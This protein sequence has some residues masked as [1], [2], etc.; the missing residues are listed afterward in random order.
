MVELADTQ[1][2]GDVTSVDLYEKILAKDF[3]DNHHLLFFILMN[4][5]NY[6]L[7]LLAFCFVSAW[8]RCVLVF[9]IDSACACIC[10]LF[11]F[12]KNLAAIYIICEPA[13][14]YHH[15][16][17]VGYATLLSLCQ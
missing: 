7:V 2:L 15:S 6:V 1:D 14:I 5:I 12:A 3:I 4:I 13:S 10:K 11:L 17:Y 9:L 16:K 8:S